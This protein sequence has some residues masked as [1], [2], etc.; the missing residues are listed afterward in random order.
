[1]FNGIDTLI[2]SIDMSHGE[3]KAVLV[4]GRRGIIT[5]NVEIV[6]AFQGQEAIELYNKLVTTNDN[7]KK[8]VDDA[9]S[10]LKGE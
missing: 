9:N 2:M 7:L 4:V 3:D 8:D 1:M 5:Q 10:Y 6:N